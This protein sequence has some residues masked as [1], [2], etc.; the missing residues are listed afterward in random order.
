MKKNYRI[1]VEALDGAPSVIPKEW[2]KNKCEGF[3]LM[4]YDGDKWNYIVENVS[5]LEL[6]DGLVRSPEL[7]EA[8]MIAQGIIAAAAYHAWR[9]DEEL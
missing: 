5:K 8:G 3:C 9:M 2:T 4:L 6:A 1:Q 7:T